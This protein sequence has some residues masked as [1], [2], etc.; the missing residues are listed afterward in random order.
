MLGRQI[1]KTKIGL[2]E[3]NPYKADWQANL[4]RRVSQTCVVCMSAMRHSS[5]SCWSI[6][7][8]SFGLI[9]IPAFE[10]ISHVF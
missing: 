5:Q 9:C 3:L 10:W 1:R 8:G 2:L 6:V 4:G 7:S